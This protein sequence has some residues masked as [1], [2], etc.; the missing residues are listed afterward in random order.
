MEAPLVIEKKTPFERTWSGP[1]GR[2]AWVGVVNNQPLGKR[3]MVTAFS[4]FVAGGVLALLMRFQLSVPDNDLIGPQVYNQLFTMHGS[5]MMY[6]FAVPFLE[7]LALYLIPLMIGSRDVAFPRLT[8]FSY[9]TYLLGGIIF[10]ASF[11]AGTIADAGWFAYVPLSG[12]EYSGKGLDFWLLG[13]AMVEIAGI[14]AGIEIVVTILKLRAPGMGLH[15]MPIFAWTLLVTGVMIIFAFTVLL[16]ATALLELDRA[17]GTRFFDPLAGGNI[18]LWQHLFWFFGHPEVYI[19]F[20]PATGIVSMV[21]ATSAGR[22]LLGYPLVVAAILL[23]GFISFGLWAHHMYTT[24]IPI[25]AL[26]FFAAASL[27]V[28]IAS[29][30]QIFAWI[31]TVWGTKPKLTTP[32]LYILGFVFIFVLGGFTGVMVAVVPFNWQ[33]HDTF[34]IVAHLH[35]VLIGGVVFPVFGGLHYW[36]PK[37]TGRML[38]ERLGHWS[39]W[40]NFVGFNVTFFPMHIMGFLGMPRRVYTYSEELQIGG[41]NMVATLGAVMLG[42]GFLVIF[43]NLLHSL[44]KGPRAGENPWNSDTLEWSVASPPPIYSYHRPP[45]VHHR[46]PLWHSTCEEPLELARAADA[47]AGA[48]ERWRATL[49][50]DVVSGRPLSIQFLAGPSTDPL[51]AAIGLLVAL[52]A[53]LTELYGGIPVGVVLLVIGLVRWLYPNEALV[54]QLQ[55]SK[56]PERAGLPLFTTGSRAVGWWGMVSLLTVVGTAFGA[57]FYSYFYLWLFSGEWPQGSLPPPS[58][59]VA[60]PAYAGLALSGG[61]AWWTWRSFGRRRVRQTFFG[62]GS[63]GFL[64]ALFVGLKIYDQ[65]TVGF[66]PQDHA[67]G[68]IFFVVGWLLLLLVVAGLG[69]AGGV[70][71]RLREHRWGEEGPMA[72]HLQLVV[73]YACFVALLAIL[74]FTVLYLSPMVL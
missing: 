3:F 60:L 22:P 56:V 19:V 32:F 66:R 71:L 38:S 47:M 49:G 8:A 57:L 35:Y 24:G 6:L 48:P 44:W 27:M 42:I 26:S 16:V 23:T 20:L 72:L 11:L 36:L 29:G 25:L 9:W 50:T 70:A 61:A 12:P 51:V 53:L 65:L 52:L 30:I 4:F 34:F 14:T 58:L 17:I 73:M 10:Y 7:G 54:R 46:N 68:S 62:L 2:W 64:A 67:Y 55:D 39:F 18:L 21:V 13:L 69:L 59:G 1:S 43:A 74:V 40:L 41:Y 31:G 37:I 45:V 63:L 33:V 28:G 5:T 15:R